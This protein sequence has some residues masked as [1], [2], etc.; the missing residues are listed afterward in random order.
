MRI[1]LTGGAGYIGSHI[2]VLL[3]GLGHEVTI[4]DNLSNSD[5]SVL[6]RISKIAGKTPDF[7]D[8][9][10]N[11]SDVLEGVLRNQNIESVIHLAGL[12]AVGESVSYPLEYFKNN[13]SGIISLLGAMNR[14]NVKSLIFSSSATVYGN[15]SYLPLDEEHPTCAVNPYGRTKL[16]CEEILSDIAN[17]DSSWRISS[18]RYFNPVG[19]HDSG[20]LGDNPSGK[21]NNL[22]PYLMRVAAGTLDHVVI[23]GDD[24]ET[25]DGTGVRDYIHVVD[26]AE[27]HCAALT[28]L[29]DR[30]LPFNVFNLGTGY[31][32]SVFQMLAAFENVSTIKI[33][34]IV[35]PR[36]P[37]DV[38]SCFASTEK[39]TEF[40]GWAAKK[41]LKDMCLSAWNFQKNRS[42]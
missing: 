16:H 35:G 19:A 37:G 10:V 11:D 8:A 1:L 5:R 4:Y 24:Y 12:K 27:G 17:S 14:A 26:V 40:L 9:D 15:P 23:F 38:A 36:R 6:G 39:A 32:H 42:F 21:P 3:L 7:F 31:G 30:E 2:A 20:L 18:L 28:E 25:L 41:T 34:Y 29:G 33:P 13:V 22:A